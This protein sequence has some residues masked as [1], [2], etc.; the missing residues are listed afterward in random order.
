MVRDHHMWGG[1][2]EPPA[3]DDAAAW[4]LGALPDDWFTQRPEVT[5]DRDEIVIGGGLPEPSLGEGETAAA[6]KLAAERGRI[7]S[8]REGTRDRRI[9]IAQQ[10]ERRYRR[11][12]AWGAV[13][14]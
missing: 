10:L 13:C 6:E 11:K 1:R 2:H 8:Y 9:K 4:I 12:V 3:A 14:G 5:I 7:A